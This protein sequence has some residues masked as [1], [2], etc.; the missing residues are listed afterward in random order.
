MEVRMRPPAR[1]RPRWNFTSRVQATLAFAMMLA[2]CAVGP[3]FKRPDP[4]TAAY[5][6][7]PAAVGPQ[8]LVYGAD[9]AA[10]WYA[11]FHSQSLNTLVQQ[12]LR[13]NPLLEG[14]RHNLLAAQY[15]LQ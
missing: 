2:G 1:S 4:P 9:V 13:A 15:E 10:D 14:A 12:A 3:N 11:L 7:P 8:S 6:A 5:P